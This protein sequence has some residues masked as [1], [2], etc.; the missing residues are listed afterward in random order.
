MNLSKTDSLGLLKN[1]LKRG[2]ASERS[3]ET[4]GKGHGISGLGEIANP[5]GIRINRYLANS[6]YGS[7]REVEQYIL[8]GR[9]KLN[10]VVI[11]TLD[12]RVKPG[13]LV[14]FDDNL[15]SLP[16]KPLYYI[17]NKPAGYIVSRKGFGDDPTIYDLLPEELKTLKYAGRLDKNSRGLLILSNDGAFIQA[18]SHPGRRLAKHYIVKASPLPPEYELQENF[19]RGVEDEGELLRA[20]RVN[21]LDREKGLVEIVLMQG[22][23]RQIRRMFKAMGSRVL[24]LYRDCVGQIDLAKTPLEEGKLLPIEPEWVFYGQEHS[25]PS[26]NPWHA[27]GK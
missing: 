15:V 8:G 6:G 22:K 16:D 18:V 12:T 21:V 3:T 7:R 17:F 14:L 10:D 25:R 9:V 1:S 27:S 4:G 5:E 26:F 13:D 2:A 24:D 19:I 11:K 20:M 23:N